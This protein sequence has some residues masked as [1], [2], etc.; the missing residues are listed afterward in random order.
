MYLYLD[1]TEKL[2]I[3]LLDENY[4]WVDYF[5]EDIRSASLRIQGIIFDN[6]GRHN[7]TVSDIKA[8]FQASGPGSYTGMRVSEGLSQ[9]FEWHDYPIFS[10]YHF[11]VP[12]LLGIEKGT[13]NANAYKGDVFYYHWENENEDYEL[14]KIESVREKEGDHLFSHYHKEPFEMIND[15]NL[16]SVMIK[17]NPKTFFQL[18]EQKKLRREPYYYRPLDVEFTKPKKGL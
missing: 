18:L 11:E 9:I 7:K 10:F 14:K 17:N 12:Q 5:E 8:V 1:T 6:L 16:T 15:E 3:G 2:V 4:Q 13:W